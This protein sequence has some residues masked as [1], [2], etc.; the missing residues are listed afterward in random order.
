[1]H[2]VN[3]PIDRSD[4]KRNPDP[5][6]ADGRSVEPARPVADWPA[7]RLL[8]QFRLFVASVLAAVYY[9]A[10]EQLTLGTR[11][12][13][14]FEI[15]HLAWFVFGLGFAYL[16]S[17]RRPA[18]ESQLYLQSYFDALCIVAL[19]YASGGVQ[20]GLVPLLIIGLALLSQ[21]V[22]V[23]QALLFAAMATLVL[24]SEELLARV[25]HGD[26]AADLEQT[27]LAGASMF[28]VAWLVTVPVRR[29][30]AR[31]VSVAND[32]RVGLDVRQIAQLNEEIVQELDSGVVVIDIA[33]DVQLINDTAR[34][35]LGAEFTPIPMPLGHLSPPLAR[36]LR[37]H[38]QSPMLG[39]RPVEVTESGQCVLPQ[40]IP[41]SGSGVLIKLDDHS[42]IFQQF[43][44]LKLASL[45]KL[46]A[47]IAHEIRNPLG[48][49]S[50]AVQLMQES[51]ELRAREGDLLDAAARNTT[52]INRIVS[53]VLQLSNRQQVRADVLDL[54]QAIDGFCRRFREENALAA[55]SLVRNGEPGI[56]VPFDPLH[57][58]QV[59]WNLCSNSRSHNAGLDVSIEI[60][61]WQAQRGV[62][63][64]DVVDDGRGVSEE[65]RA[66]VFEPFFTTND[67]GSGLGLYIIRELCE[68][69]KAR[70][71]CIER[72][73]G[74]HFRLTLLTAQEMAA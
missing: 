24:L 18:A 20:S 31:D 74:A 13:Q 38:R 61:C 70:I 62:A 53:D 41:L 16:I 32:F 26:A 33:G 42:H 43:Q 8:N 40:Y 56:S 4:S 34:V 66:K 50:H 59:L 48:A 72:E 25:L 49:I 9:G 37:E 58:D 63:V 2:H 12:P 46:S 17:I 29:L 67:Q 7:L 64:V 65:E 60:S 73:R 52:R 51:P 39:C 5:D 28:V 55:G 36:D 11:D 15:V 71:E 21:L 54:D 23:R 44:Q 69:N 19:M 30:A 35:L 14:L 57:L 45:G 22:S 47:S 1:M 27:A 3:P 6:S 10:D 68:L